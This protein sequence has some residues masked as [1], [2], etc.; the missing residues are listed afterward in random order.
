MTSATPARPILYVIPAYPPLGSQPFVVNEMVE[1]ARSGR[2]L[3]VLGLRP[4]PPEPVRHGTFEALRPT[5][6]LPARLVDA[7]TLGLAVLAALRWPGRTLAVLAGLHRA[8]GAN[9]Y[10]HLRLL[11]ITPKALAAAWRL[12]RAG[13]AHVHAHF[14]STTADCA[15]IVAR[16]LGVPYSFTAHAY[17]IYSTDLRVRNDTLA[18]KARH[19]ARV[20]AISDYGAGVLRAL[21][22]PAEQGRVRTVRV[23][24][25]LELFQPAPWPE[26]G[27]ALRLLSV[28]RW[29]EKK[30][31]D[32][33]L[34]ACA[35]LRER[36]VLFE[37][38]LFGDGPLR[39]ALTAQW[40]RLGLAE[41]VEL[42]GPIPQEEVARQ[43]RACHVFV[44]PCRRDRTGDMDGIPTV[45]ME[46]MATGRPVVSCAISGIGELVRHEE[47]GLLTRPDDPAAVADA[48][49]RLAADRGLARR[50]G[51]RG[52]E[53]VE[54]QHDQRRNARAVLAVLAE[55]AS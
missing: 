7:S 19:A 50:L 45:F 15:A 17:D 36:G 42:G 8:A 11:A 48:I 53:L 4:G 10:A 47:T 9:P 38:R 13:I 2:P 43:M 18:W 3:F 28:A 25:P 6:V 52:R 16:L 55:D 46:A 41:A 44:L 21:L 39:E 23:G 54:A 14:A 49:A 37:L 31:L 29:C 24:I 34:D 35:L 26:D 40:R 12:R 22:P 32:T 1:V 33:L 30:G 51:A 27:G 20:I 5:A